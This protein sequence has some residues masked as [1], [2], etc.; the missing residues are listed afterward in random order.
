MTID[1]ELLPAMKSS[2]KFI[3]FTDF[4]GTVTLKDS[5]FREVSACT[6]SPRRAQAT[7]RTTQAMTT[8]YNLTR[9]QN[10]KPPFPTDSAGRRT[11]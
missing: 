11:T 1:Y 8:W 6:Q 4:D 5:M 7:D 9:R 3:F 10:H 2:P